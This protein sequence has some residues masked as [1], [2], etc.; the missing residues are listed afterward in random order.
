VVRSPEELEAAFQ[1][2][3]SEAGAAFGRADVYGVDLD[4]NGTV[5]HRDHLRRGTPARMN[6]R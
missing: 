6:P 4:V 5:P 2:C 3:E 1:R